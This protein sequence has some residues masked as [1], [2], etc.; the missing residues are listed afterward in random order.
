MNR[1]F[2]KSSSPGNQR[3]MATLLM[4]VVLLVVITVVSLLTAKVTL[5]AP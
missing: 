3:G 4:S 5:V 2:K 1:Q